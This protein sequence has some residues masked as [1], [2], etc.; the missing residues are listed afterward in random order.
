MNNRI[1]L[2]AIETYT[3]TTLHFRRLIPPNPSQISRS[4][5]MYNTDSATCASRVSNCIKEI[6]QWMAANRLAMNPAKTDVLWCSTSHQPSD[7]TYTNLRYS[8]TFLWSAQS[9]RG[10][11]QWLVTE[12]ARQWADIPLLQLS[13]SHQELP[14]RTHPDHCSDGSQEPG[15]HK[16]WLLQRPSGRLHQTDAWQAATG[17]EL[18]WESYILG[19][20]RQHVTPLL[21]DHL[22]WLRARERISFKL[23]VQGNTQPC[24]MLSERDVHS[25]VHCSLPFRSPFRH[26]WWF[27]RTQNKA[28]TRLPG[29]LCGWSGRLEHSFGTYIINV[30]SDAQDTSVFSILLQ[31]LTVFQST[32]SEHCAAPL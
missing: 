29:I 22:H 6:D 23:C 20:S 15:C 8:S 25:S 32:S 14:T 13:T 28:T 7:H 27:N 18:F 21:R 1:T 9:R 2:M 16:A 17:I 30:Q 4:S 26:S 19:Y 31:W 24:T 10:I 3:H 12:G 11:R 5:Y